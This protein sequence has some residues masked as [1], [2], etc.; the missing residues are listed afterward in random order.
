[1]QLIPRYLVNNRTT[2]VADVAGFITEYRPVYS[3]EIQIHQ[4]IDNVLEFKVL[5]ADQKPI[6]LTGYTPK[7]QAFDENKILIIERNG[8]QLTKNGS[9]IKGVFSVTIT[10][11]DL[12]NVK[13][14]FLSYNIVLEDSDCVDTLT[15]TTGYFDACATMKVNTCAMPILKDSK[16]ISDFLK[17]SEDIPYW[18]TS[19][20]SAEPGINGNEALHTA[21]IYTNGYIGDIV[22]QATLDNQVSDGTDWANVDTITLNGNETEPTPINFNGVFNHLR[23]KATVDPE[24]KLTKILVRN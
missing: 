19:S 20:I 8:V 2:I 1:M 3:R 22:V 18:T 9:D 6:S 13:G 7:L 24:E 4:G 23:F 17:V 15:Y 11:N 21:A 5:N 16:T 10:Q 12:L 14:Q